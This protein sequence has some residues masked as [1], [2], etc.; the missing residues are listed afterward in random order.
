MLSASIWKALKNVTSKFTTG[1]LMALFIAVSALGF[2]GITSQAMAG[3]CND[4]AREAF[5]ACEAEAQD[6]YHIARGN[7]RNLSDDDDRDACFVSAEE[8]LAEALELCPEQRGARL[9]LCG[10]LGDVPYDPI[11]DPDDFVD[12]EDV[13]AFTPNP[14]FPL[15][16]GTVRDYEVTDD[17]GEVIEKIK[18][19]VLDE[20]K[21]IL[22]VNC[23]VVRDRVWEIDEDGEKSLIEDTFDWYAQDLTGNVWYFGEISKEFEDGELVSLAGSWKSGVDGAKPGILMW[24]YPAGPDSAPPQAVYRQEFFL[25][26]AEDIGEFVG[27][28]DA[29]AVRG[30][31]YRNVLKTKDY[32]PIDPAVFEYKYY[33]PGVGVILEEGF[34]DGDSTGEQ[35][36]LVKMK[37]IGG[38]DDDDDDHD[39]DDHKRRR[40]RKYRRRH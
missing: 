10:D 8:E 13:G 28:V 25:G 38:D 4:T 9:D 35:V 39:D 22:G 33:A 36:E 7:C 30:V 12:F 37:I 6:D 14:Y 18:V 34:E 11:I 21:E 1:F 27:F 23:I 19:E 31:T 2:L 15:V 5:A 26:E 16:S 24:G 3:D 40:H 17:G 29:I 20:T 32:T